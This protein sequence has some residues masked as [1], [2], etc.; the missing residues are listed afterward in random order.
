[1][2]KAELVNAVAEAT[3]QTKLN[4][5]NTVAALLHSLTATLAKGERVTLVGFGTFER[6][7]RQARY[8]VNPQN[9]KQKLKIE[10]AKV[11]VF[12]AGQELKD[13]V[14]G[15][16]KQAPLPKAAPAAKPAAKKAA[17]KPAKK[18][19]KPAKKSAPAKKAAAKKAPAKKK[20]AAKKKR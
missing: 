4:V 16:A 14:D 3:G 12:R 17:A 15:R 7:Q 6:R 8:G 19:A 1:M 20:P 9:P 2:N 13:V 10:A 11:P 18:A 5:H